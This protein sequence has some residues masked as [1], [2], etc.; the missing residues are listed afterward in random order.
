MPIWHHTQYCY[1]T[2]SL[3]FLMPSQPSSHPAAIRMSWVYEFCFVLFCSFVLF[4]FFKFHVQVKSYSI[5]LSPFEFFHSAQYPLGPSMLSQGRVSSFFYDCVIF[6][7]LYVPLL[8]SPSDGHLVGLH[9][10]TTVNIAAGDKW[11]LMSSDYCSGFLRTIPRKGMAGPVLA[12]CYSLCFKV[13]FV[14]RGC[15]YPSSCV[16]PSTFTKHLVLSASSESL[17]VFQSM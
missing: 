5:S 6:R 8:Y 15:C 2:T 4:C 12:S 7:C 14:R 17:C 11:M 13:C 1:P 16:L 9:V 3:H 10:L